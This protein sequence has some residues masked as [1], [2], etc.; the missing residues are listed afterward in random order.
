MAD[1]SNKKASSVAE[2]NNRDNNPDYKKFSKKE[3]I[4]F[5][6]ERDQELVDLTGKLTTLLESTVVLKNQH[7]RLEADFINFRKRNQKERQALIAN[8][9]EDVI[10]NFLNVKMN[11]LATIVDK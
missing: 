8:V 5:L 10:I 6:D 7:L 2:D 4:V 1:D 9:K 11:S 3:L